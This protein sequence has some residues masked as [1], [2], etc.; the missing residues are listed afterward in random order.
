MAFTVRKSALRPW[1]VKVQLLVGNESGEVQPAEFDFVLHFKPFGEDEFDRIIKEGRAAFDVPASV[2][3]T[4]SGVD[5]EALAPIPVPPE[6]TPAETLAINAR[7]F[8]ALVGDWSHL[9]DEHGNPLP[10]SEAAF[11]ALIVGPDGLAISH[12]IN[13]A[14]TQLRFGIAPA[15]NAPPSPAPG[16]GTDGGALGATTS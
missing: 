10:Y 16:P 14:L 12:G 1:P 13:V 4:A 15:K 2:E 9:A 11:A 5:G 6:P 8:P 7:I 3:H